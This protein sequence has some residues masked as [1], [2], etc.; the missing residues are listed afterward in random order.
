[1]IKSECIRNNTNEVFPCLM[2]G[3][4][5]IIALVII[6]RNEGKKEY[7]ATVLVDDMKYRIGFNY[8]IEDITLYSPLPKGTKV[9]ITN[10]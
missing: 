10:E 2:I 1:M 8:I 9:T 3:P 5:D 4:T 6:I 7:W